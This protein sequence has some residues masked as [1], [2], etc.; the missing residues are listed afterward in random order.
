MYFQNFESR[1]FYQINSPSQN[2]FAPQVLAKYSA[3]GHLGVDKHNNYVVLIRIGMIDV[4]GI[5]LSERQKTCLTFLCEEIEKSVIAARNEPVKYKR[6]PNAI[7][8]VTAIF[9]MDGFSM[10][11]ITYK[12]GTLF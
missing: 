11:N 1:R 3:I 5:L 4:K 2:Y 10:R 8:Q 6:S 7:Y 9:D 12:P